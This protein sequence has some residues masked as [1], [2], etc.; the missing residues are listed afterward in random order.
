MNGSPLMGSGVHFRKFRTCCNTLA[1]SFISRRLK[2]NGKLIR[3]SLKA[4][5]FEEAKLALHDFVTRETKQRHVVG[6]PVTFAEARQLYEASTNH[7]A[8]IQ[9]QAG[10]I[11]V[12]APNGCSKTGRGWTG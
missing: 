11:G 7:D 3:R 10:D 1:R 5:T 6:A 9:S 2:V 4:N 8:A 12:G